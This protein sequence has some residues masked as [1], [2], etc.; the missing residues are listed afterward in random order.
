MRLVLF[1]V[2][3]LALV[4]LLGGQAMAST[5]PHLPAHANPAAASVSSSSTS[6]DLSVP[7]AATA[8]T[9]VNSFANSWYKLTWWILQ[10]QREYHRA[11]A[12][13]IEALQEQPG[14]R[15]TWVLLGL[16]FLYGVFHA[17]GPGHGK[18]VLTTYL[19]TQPEQLR[20]GLVLSVIAALLQ[21]VTA[22][23]L[24]TVLVQGL[25]WLAREAFNSVIYLERLSFGVIAV[26][27]LL[28]LGRSI[29][30]TWRLYKS[31]RFSKLTS[32]TTNPAAVCSD[33][34]KA[35]HVAP[36]Q[37]EGRSWLQSASLL[38]SIG[39]RPC[40]GAVLV[41]VA[42]NLLGLWWAGVLA[43]VAMSVGTAITVSALAVV[44][45]QSR[46][47]ASKLIKLQGN[48]LKVVCIVATFAGGL[49]I[50][51][52]GSSLLA[53]SWTSPIALKIF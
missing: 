19:L 43:V 24:V 42:A 14:W 28:L 21:G 32:A 26:L 11:L 52:L 29:R 46:H 48:S 36:E 18:A 13:G 41:L 12:T 4:G 2:I 30:Q 22:I 3:F 25:G 35:H 37:L 33:C 38:L 5:L 23:V 51:L 17:A 44:A 39:L 40:S 16:S 6:S 15:T 9:K 53:G 31:T 7:T 1:N 27:G 34:G 50:L 45:V 8:T 49:V 20:R 10:K 47:L